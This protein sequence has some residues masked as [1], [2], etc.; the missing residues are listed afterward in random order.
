RG[1]GCGVWRRAGVTLHHPTMSLPMMRAAPPPMSTAAVSAY[2][3]GQGPIL[4][5]GAPRSPVACH[6]QQVMAVSACGTSADRRS[7]FPQ[8]CGQPA[9]AWPLTVQSGGTG[10]PRPSFPPHSQQVV[11]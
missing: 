3:H 6:Q 7:S 4:V 10:T 2:M 9:Q 8:G 11:V 5:A 1:E